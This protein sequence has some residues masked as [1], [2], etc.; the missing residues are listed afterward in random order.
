MQSGSKYPT[1]HWN[2]YGQAVAAHYNLQPSGKERYNGPCPHCGGTDRFWIKSHQGE[3]KVNCN[4]CGD[5]KAIYAEMESDGVIPKPEAQQ[6][7]A[8]KKP[9]VTDFDD[10]TPYHIR[11]GVSLIGAS[12]DGHTVVIRIFNS[13]REQVG[14]QRITPD[15]R[16]MFSKGMSQSGAFGVVGKPYSGTVYIAE[17]WATSVSVY[18]ATGNPVIFALNS[19]NLPKV[20]KLLPDLFASAEFVVAADNDEPGIKAA[21][22]S[23]FKY[24]LPPAGMDWNDVHAANGLDAVKSGVEN[25]IAAGTTLEAAAREVAGVSADDMNFAMD[26]KGAIP[27]NHHNA[28][29]I[30]TKSEDWRHVFAFDEFAQRKMVMQP[31]PGSAGNP[32][33]FS[34]RE[35]KDSDYISV[36]RWFNLNGFLRANKNT[37]CDVV[38]A[39]CHENII[40]PVRHYLEDLGRKADQDPEDDDYLDQW[41]MRMLGVEPDNEEHR[42]YVYEVSRKWIIS[43]VARALNP[44]CKAD[45]V[46]IMEGSQGAGKSTALR[47]LAGDEWFGDALPQ[48][49]TKDA[50]DYLRGKWIVELAE[51]SNINKAEVEIVKAF[52]SRTEERFRPAYG[53]SEICYPRHCIFA[54]TTNK[55]DYLRDETGNRRFWPIKCGTIDISLIKAEREKLLGEAVRAYQ[56]GEE[57][58]LSGEA[59]TYARTEQDKRLAVDE[60]TG[61]IETY[62]QTRPE[63]AITQ[64]ASDVFDISAKD[65]NRMTQNRISSILSAIGYARSGKFT[66]GD[67]RNKAKFVRETKDE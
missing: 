58:W 32:D 46:L 45:G 34:P 8:I 49:G 11:K 10:H 60:W 35:I 38:D 65:V 62:C 5:F 66:T 56:N 21:Q 59:E 48:M 52:V 17:G 26:S 36:V 1:L 23:G 28:M 41:A 14:T 43:A 57:W 22:A 25:L 18:M 4:Q 64:I 30:I 29:E 61:D 63:V 16:K 53:R 3:L 2:E 51:L 31:I 50:S 54:G 42:L 39:S 37:V 24:A 47:V 55:S 13:D 19:G 6:P 40:S 20:T 27:F 33:K 9:D 44:G 15:G 12:L 67:L 7:M